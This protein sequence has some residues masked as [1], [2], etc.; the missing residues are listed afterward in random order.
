M[1]V[2]KKWLGCLLL[3]VVCVSTLILLIVTSRDTPPSEAH[4]N[5]LPIGA[6]VSELPIANGPQ[7]ESLELS[8]IEEWVDLPRNPIK[9]SVPKNRII[10]NEY[11]TFQRK[12]VPEKNLEI[13]MR[14]VYPKFS[15]VITYSSFP[16]FA[17]AYWVDFFFIQGK[18]VDRSWS[19]MPG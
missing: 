12:V 16:G 14:N 2:G 8:S 1:G 4:L 10:T 18:C 19:Y 15:G 5:L 11:G 6:S 3:P 7:L 17:N 9:S 13:Y